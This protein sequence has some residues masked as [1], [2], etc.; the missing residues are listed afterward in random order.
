VESGLLSLPKTAR[1]RGGGAN[2]E[3]YSF[4]KKVVGN[5]SGGR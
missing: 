4:A 5:I 1:R 2:G 3:V